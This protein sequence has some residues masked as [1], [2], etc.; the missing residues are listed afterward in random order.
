MWVSKVVLVTVLK[1]QVSKA[2]ARSQIPDSLYPVSLLTE[3]SQFILYEKYK[4]A[5][6]LHYLTSYILHLIS[7]TAVCF[8][9][10]LYFQVLVFAIH[11]LP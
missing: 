11:I 4:I 7:L 1:R 5:Q 8:P 3:L 6:L 9:L 2:H 10:M